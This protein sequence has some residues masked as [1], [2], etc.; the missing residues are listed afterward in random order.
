MINYLP[1]KK[2]KHYPCFNHCFSFGFS[3]YALCFVRACYWIYYSLC[4]SLQ[5]WLKAFII[6]SLVKQIELYEC[7]FD[8]LEM[9]LCSWRLL[10]A[11][12]DCWMFCVV[13]VV[14]ESSCG[15]GT[16]WDG[17]SLCPIGSS[18]ACPSKGVSLVAGLRLESVCRQWSFGGGWVYKTKQ[19]AH[20]LA[21]AWGP[22]ASHTAFA[23]AIWQHG[24]VTC[25]SCAVLPAC[26]LVCSRFN[27]LVADSDNCVLSS[28]LCD[29]WTTSHL[30]VSVWNTPIQ[31]WFPFSS[32]LEMCVFY[33]HTSS[34]IH[35]YTS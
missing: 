2:W 10:W 31:Q 5:M 24:F 34:S 20:P 21:V 26:D 23:V 8:V 9:M 17:G 3:F 12:H 30:W 1:F 27:I 35:L 6:L 15:N 32:A 16:C 11:L 33:L 19:M 4:R 22:R 28:Y 7:C 25:T 18:P 13:D 29:T 14:P